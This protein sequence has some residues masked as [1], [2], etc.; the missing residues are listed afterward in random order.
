MATKKTATQTK[1]FEHD[2][3][4]PTT[5]NS[6]IASV[7]GNSMNATTTAIK[8]NNVKTLNQYLQTIPEIGDSF[9]P[10]SLLEDVVE[11]PLVL[12][13]WKYNESQFDGQKQY[14][15]LSAYD[16]ENPTQRLKIVCGAS[17]I[18]DLLKGLDKSLTVE[19][20]DSFAM[21]LV[22]RYIE[23]GTHGYYMPASYPD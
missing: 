3:I 5:D 23:S 21:S 6:T 9:A 17:I 16:Y 4:A 1:M 13:G 7:K 8:S 22:I 12:T 20:R 15:I 11:R 10:V 2:A 18:M 19:E 14:A